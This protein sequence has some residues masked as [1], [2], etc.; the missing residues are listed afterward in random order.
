MNNDKHHFKA[1]VLLEKYL[2]GR[3]T[4]EEEAWVEQWYL[5]LSNTSNDLTEE[6][7]AKDLI[8]LNHR[9]SEITK[10][11]KYRL[12]PYISSAAAII[13]VS[14]S[15]FL[16]WNKKSINSGNE[17]TPSYV[18]DVLP[19]S[20]KATL[21][22]NGSK[23]ITLSENQQGLI[24]KGGAISYDDGTA[25]ETLESVNIVA[26]T[27]PVA[28]QYQITLPDGTH[29]WLNAASSISYPTQ[30][31]NN[32]REI[33]VTGEVYLEVA[34]DVNKPF[35]VNSAQQKIEVLGTS[36]NLNAYQD[37]GKTLTT[38]SEGSIRLTNIKSNDRVLLK[39]G[40]QSIVSN[41]TNIK[42]GKVDTDE[43]SSWR[44]GTYILNNET[45]D[46][47]ARQ[48]ERWY[49]VKVDMHPYENIQLSAIISRK[50]KLSEVLQAIEL[51]T[52]VKF[53]IEGRRVTTIK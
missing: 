15:I 37:N 31:A 22:L 24:N 44:Y 41:D 11:R 32:K 17:N 43:A 52:G 14:L 5:D 53:K 4:Q 35:I 36:F 2:E 45:L 30:F 49:D 3:C 48:I 26:L 50:A 6:E 51:K 18:Q 23:N 8:E 12:I 21:T 47:Y 13:L 25:I 19:G 27:T 20:N 10:Q 42:V 16:F 1:K 39:P 28:G 40:H 9:L 38:L 29:A 34:E 33:S 46:Q 7:L